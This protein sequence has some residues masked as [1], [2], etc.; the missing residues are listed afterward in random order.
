MKLEVVDNHLTQES[1]VYAQVDGKAVLLG[2]ISIDRTHQWSLGEW[3]LNRM[4]LLGIEPPPTMRWRYGFTVANRSGSFAV[5]V[6]PD[7]DD[8]RL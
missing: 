4:L 7:D 3:A 2:T 6:P 8:D 5:I 1:E